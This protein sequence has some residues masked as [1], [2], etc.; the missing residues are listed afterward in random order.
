MK[1]S[2]TWVALLPIYFI[3]IG[4]FIVTAI[5]SSRTVETI[6]NVPKR[7]TV[8]IDAGHGGEDGGATS[9]TGVL[10][11]KFK[12]L[13]PSPLGHNT[14]NICKKYRMISLQQSNFA[15]Y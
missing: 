11:S 15:L 9:C 3:V 13:L 4:V 6:A 5:L 14:Q 8:I 12:S 1:R 2:Q 7:H 10:E